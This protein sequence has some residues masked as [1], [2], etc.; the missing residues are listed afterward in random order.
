MLWTFLL[1]RFV[2]G[3]PLLNALARAKN[4]T[5]SLWHSQGQEWLRWCRAWWSQLFRAMAEAGLVDPRRINDGIAHGCEFLAQWPSS[6]PLLEAVAH[7][8]RFVLERRLASLW[9][10]CL[11]GVPPPGQRPR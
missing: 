7:W 10:P 6:S 3:L 11:G 1:A 2:E 4:Q 8:R 9:P 5:S